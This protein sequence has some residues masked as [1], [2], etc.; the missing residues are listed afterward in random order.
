MVAISEASFLSRIS[1]WL[2]YP[3][4]FRAL[5]AKKV[6][7]NRGCALGRRIVLDQRFVELL[8]NS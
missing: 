8:E 2:V 7:E 5:N 6:W 1:K 4:T 3:S